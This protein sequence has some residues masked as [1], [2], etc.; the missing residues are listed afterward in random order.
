MMH[1]ITRLQQKVLEGI[2]RRLVV[3]GLTHRANIVEVLRLL[4]QVCAEEFSED[5]DATQ[6]DFLRGC[7][8]EVLLPSEVCSARMCDCPCHG[9]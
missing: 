9:D 5:N 3:Q 8:E 4:G 6:Y 2:F 1:S 7:V